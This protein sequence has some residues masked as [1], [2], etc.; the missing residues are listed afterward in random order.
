MRTLPSLESGP[1]EAETRS[2][3]DAIF[4][5]PKESLRSK[6]IM[7]CFER[8]YYS[9]SSGPLFDGF[10]GVVVALSRTCAIDGD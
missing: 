6:K 10:E 7:Y 4:C 2:V 9:E 1:V 8:G 3:N 5:L